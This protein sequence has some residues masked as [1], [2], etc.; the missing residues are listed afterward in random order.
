MRRPRLRSRHRS[1]GGTGLEGV[2]LLQ[3][4]SLSEHAVEGAGTVGERQGGEELLPAQSGV[5]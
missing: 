1:S 2:R 4:E 3:K 5:N